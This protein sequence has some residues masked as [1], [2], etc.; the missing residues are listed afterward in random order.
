MTM[1]QIASLTRFYGEQLALEGVGFSV[2]A[3][4]I[5]CLIGADGA[6]KTTLLEAITGLLPVHSGEICFRNRTLPCTDGAAFAGARGRR[7]Q[8]IATVG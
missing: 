8:L 3:G 1:L 7:T 5:L 4:E 6:G 2:L